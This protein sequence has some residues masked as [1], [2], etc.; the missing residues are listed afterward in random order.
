MKQE[1]M[2]HHDPTKIL[3]VG[4]SGCGKT[5]WAN[6]FIIKSRYQSYFIFDH[7]RQ[8]STRNGLTPAMTIAQIL[9]QVKQGFVVFDPSEMFSDTKVALEW[10]AQYAYRMSE[11][12]PGTKLFFCDELQDLTGT[13]DVSEYVRRVLVSGRNRGLDFLACSL[14]YNMVHNS[15]RGQCTQTIAFKTEEKLA[16]SALTERGFKAEEIAQLKPG[17]YVQRDGRTGNEVRGKVF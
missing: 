14:Q 12:L 10:F 9:P 8:F 3:A 13:H 15:I 6:E 16:L 5:R 11:R 1:L 4:M 17:E 2:L 7:D